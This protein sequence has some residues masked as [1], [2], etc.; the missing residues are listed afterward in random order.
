MTELREMVTILVNSSDGFDDCWGPF[1]TLL[2]KYWPQQ[3]CQIL[4]NT[5][6]KDYVFSGL[7]VRA[8]KVAEGISERLPWSECLIR[9]LDQIDTPLFL[10][11][12]ED[13][14]IDRPVLHESI[15]EA[16]KLMMSDPTIGHVALTKHGPLKPYEPYPVEGYELVRQKSRYRISTQAG[17]WRTEALKKYLRSDEN[18]WMFEIFGTWRAQRE[19]ETFLVAA[20]QEGVMP[21][22]YVHTGIVKGKWLDQMPRIFAD[23]AINVDFSKRGFYQ[24]KPPM[25]HKIEV[26]KKL[27]ERPG[28]FLQQYFGID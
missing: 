11:F 26:L 27:L 6:H 10:Y 13:Y 2:K 3:D 15:V 16:A 17:L 22:E 14:F 12:Q 1:F 7:D 24:P 23:N 21:I 8:S 20:P 19:T 4:L 5:E 25:L 28:Y 18:G 9:A